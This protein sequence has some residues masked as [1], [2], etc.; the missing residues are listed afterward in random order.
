MKKKFFIAG[1]TGALLLTGGGLLYQTS[2]AE[3]DRN[4]TIDIPS[5]TVENVSQ[6]EVTSVNVQQ[7]EEKIAPD[8]DA[9]Q[10]GVDLSQVPGGELR[11]PENI[12][13]PSATVSTHSTQSSSEISSLEQKSL[14][15][16]KF[17]DGYHFQS[18]YQAQNGTEFLVLQ[19]PIETDINTTIQA[20]KEFYKETVELT[21]INGHQAAYVDGKERKVVHIFAKDRAFAVSTYNGSLDDALNVAKQIAEQE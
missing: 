15:A 8:P 4:T 13:G 12:E 19:S 14:N 16:K 9:P 6:D 18:T 20:I 17:D 3:A 10:F 11:I 2:A 7:S 5:D 21:E 1:L